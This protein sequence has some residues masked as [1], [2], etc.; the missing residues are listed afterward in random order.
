M[1]SFELC[2]LGGLTVITAILLIA[3]VVLIVIL[4]RRGITAIATVIKI[5]EKQKYVGSSLKKGIA[6]DYRYKYLDRKGYERYGTLYKNQPQREFD[7]GDTIEVIY[8]E[9]APHISI[10]KPMCRLIRILPPII[11]IIL[12]VLVSILIINLQGV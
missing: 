4:E 5:E 7:V 9:Y 1:L 10:Y 11:A 12:C 2:L 8:T 3:T 6:Y